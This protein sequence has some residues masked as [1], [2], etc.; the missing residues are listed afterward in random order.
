[1]VVTE[2]HVNCRDA[3]GANAVNSMAEAVAPM[4]E[5]ITGGRVF[6]RIVSN[7]A[8]KRL[9]RAWA[10]VP[11]EAVGGEEVVDGIVHASALASADPYR[12]ATHN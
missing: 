8:V 5:R 4:I 6:L 1:M 12:A 10:T 7:L 2:L 3:M 11:K 9:A